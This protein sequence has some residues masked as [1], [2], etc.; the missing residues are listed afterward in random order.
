MSIQNHHYLHWSLHL[1]LRQSLRHSMG[2]LPRLP[3]RLG[4]VLRAVRAGPRGREILRRTADAAAVGAECRVLYALQGEETWV[5][6]I[7]MGKDWRRG[8]SFLE[9]I[10]NWSLSIHVCV[11]INTN[12]NLYKSNIM[13]SLP[14]QAFPL[15]SS[16]LP[17]QPP[18]P[19]FPPNKT[20]HFP[21]F[22]LSYPFFLFLLHVHEWRM[23]T[24]L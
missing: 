17:R 21:S 20:I 19:P 14:F 8:I 2:T 15:S 6:Q 11:C 22:H 24:N 16:S 4:A 5:E 12:K 18:S 3:P 23:R 9:N 10:L 13:S 1:P 7:V